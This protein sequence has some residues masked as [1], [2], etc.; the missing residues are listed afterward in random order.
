MHGES[1]DQA[2]EVILFALDRLTPRDRFN[3][4]RFANDTETLFSSAQPFNADTLR[5]ARAFVG[6]LCAEGGTMM[7][8][9]LERAFRKPAEQGRLRQIVFLTD[10]AVG[11][12]SE[13]FRF[14]SDEMAHSR[15]FTV[16]I[17]SA[18]NTHF[19]RRSAEIGRGTFTYHRRYRRGCTADFPPH[20][21]IAVSRGNRPSPELAGDS[22]EATSRF[23]LRQ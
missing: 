14:I 20:D 12:E 18:P 17:G 8:P 6:A 3:V 9:A 1:I 16:G 13:L 10:G 23:T 15:L 7:R 21:Q 2:K 11:N 5:Q 22:P 19:M 4:I